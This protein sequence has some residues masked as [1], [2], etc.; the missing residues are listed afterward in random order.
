MT[1]LDQV[2]VTRKDMTGEQNTISKPTKKG[3]FGLIFP[4]IQQ[5]PHV[6]T[7]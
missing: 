6:W 3:A 5:V 2:C 7:A 1:E 4:E